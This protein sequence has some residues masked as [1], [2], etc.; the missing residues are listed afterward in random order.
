[1]IRSAGDKHA[2]RISG[3]YGILKVLHEVSKGQITQ[4]RAAEQLRLSERQVRRL[5]GKLGQRGD[6][7]V[8]HGLRGRASNRRISAET[9]QRG[10]EE[11]SQVSRPE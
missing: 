5:I 7:A 2:N 8:V 1:M 11:L 6:A 3:P 10:L 9:A 4:K